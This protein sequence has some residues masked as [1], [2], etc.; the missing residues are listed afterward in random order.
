MYTSSIITL[1]IIA[2][3]PVIAAVLYGAR[4]YLDLATELN[5][6]NDRLNKISELL[7]DEFDLRDDED[8]DDV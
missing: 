7:N 3:I 6:H 5:D 2:W 1:F 4:L 8:E